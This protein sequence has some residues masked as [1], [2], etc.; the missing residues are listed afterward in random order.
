MQEKVSGKE[1][2]KGP[3]V[4]GRGM[5]GLTSSICRGGASQRGGGRDILGRKRGRSCNDI[6]A[7][8]N[9]LSL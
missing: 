6:S 2:G 9:S 1:R 8:M 4:R 7:S 5:R 3:G